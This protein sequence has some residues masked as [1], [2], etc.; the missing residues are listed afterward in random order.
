MPGG[1]LEPQWC[2]G[3]IV[4]QTLADLYDTPETEAVIDDA[5]PEVNDDHIDN[6]LDDLDS[7]D[8]SDTSDTDDD[9]WWFN[10]KYKGVGR[11]HFLPSSHIINMD[12]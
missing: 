1:H 8:V 12:Q 11:A 6:E 9:M 2:D 4:P 10:V 3:E 5:S 7:S